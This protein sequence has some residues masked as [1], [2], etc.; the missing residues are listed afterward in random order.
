MDAVVMCYGQERGNVP[1]CGHVLAV[2][3]P[4]FDRRYCLAAGQYRKHLNI[5]MPVGGPNLFG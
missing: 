3:G 1:T 2:V 5:I 4:R